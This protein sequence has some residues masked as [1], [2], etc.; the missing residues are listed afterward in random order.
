MKNLKTTN[1]LEFNA[2]LRTL[3]RMGL[4]YN[5]WSLALIEANAYLRAAENESKS[6]K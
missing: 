3:K 5:N 4:V 6:R 2:F 1:L